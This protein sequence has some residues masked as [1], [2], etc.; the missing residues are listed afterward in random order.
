M[1]VDALIYVFDVARK[2]D[3]LI[4]MECVCGVL[5]VFGI[6]GFVVVDCMIG[7]LFGGEKV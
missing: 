5:G 7:S 1:E 3:K 2:V 4:M 6:I